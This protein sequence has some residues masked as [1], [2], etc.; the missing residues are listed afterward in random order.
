MYLFKLEYKGH[1]NGNWVFLL[2]PTSS[3]DNNTGT[4]NTKNKQNNHS[5]IHMVLPY[6]KGF[7]KSMRTFVLRWVSRSTLRGATPSK[8]P[9]GIKDRD[10]STEKSGVIY[11]YKCDRF[12]CD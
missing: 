9:S 4:N 1:R 10:N 2:S 7:S 12:D 11:R 8:P 6:T 3:R 5:K